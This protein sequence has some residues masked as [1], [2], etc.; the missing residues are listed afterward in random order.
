MMRR[1]FGFVW[2]LAVAAVLSAVLT[3]CISVD[4]VGQDFPPL[5]EG[6]QVMFFDA[7]NPPPAGEY[8]S[9]GRATVTVPNGYDSVAVREKLADTAREHGT[10]AVQIVSV[11]E[12]LINRYYADNEESAGPILAGR[13]TGGAF[14]RRVDGTPAEVDSFGQVVD[15]NRHYKKEYERIVKVLFLMKVQ[16]HQRAVD[17]RR[18]ADQEK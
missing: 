10:S 13:D 12:H 14:S 17:A 11:T 8:Q 18:R 1:C 6:Q 9:I 15:P 5:P 3:G 16:D 7:K 4:Y 2:V